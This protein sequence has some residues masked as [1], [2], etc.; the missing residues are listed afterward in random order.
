MLVEI[1]QIKEKNSN[2]FAHHRASVPGYLNNPS[3]KMAPNDQQN[4]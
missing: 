2:F 4:K 3:I 1:I